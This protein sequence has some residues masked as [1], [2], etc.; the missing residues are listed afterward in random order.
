VSGRCSGCDGVPVEDESTD[1]TPGDGGKSVGSLS[2]VEIAGLDGVSGKTNG[3][4][5]D[6]PGG[7]RGWEVCAIAFRHRPE[8]DWNVTL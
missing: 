4:I 6:D 2:D 3:E 8:G 7:R 5:G 1:S